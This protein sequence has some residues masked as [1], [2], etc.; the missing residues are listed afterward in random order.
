MV[1]RG[2]DWLPARPP[3]IYAVPMRCSSDYTEQETT[4]GA[5]LP[6]TLPDGQV[7]VEDRTRTRLE[8]EIRNCVFSAAAMP[9][10]NI[11]IR[12]SR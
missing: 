12:R 7:C 4:S 6:L 11:E 10:E 5:F 8:T 3:E 1:R 9:C 2:S